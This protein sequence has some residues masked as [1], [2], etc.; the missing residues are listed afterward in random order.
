MDTPIAVTDAIKGARR[1][2]SWIQSVHFP[3]EIDEKCCSFYAVRTVH[4]LCAK[5]TC[6]VNVFLFCIIKESKLFADSDVADL[7]DSREICMESEVQYS[8]FNVNSNQHSKT[9]LNS[10]NG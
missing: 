2:H 1:I 10:L 5:R 7:N 4:L 6:V 3:L 9:T 8:V